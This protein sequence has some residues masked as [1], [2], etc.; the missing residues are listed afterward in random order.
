V[1]GN[2]AAGNLQE[3]VADKEDPTCEARHGSGDTQFFIHAAGHGKSDIYA[4]HI[5]NNAGNKNR[6]NNS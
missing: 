6:R 4:V 5:G 1:H 3:Q 2:L